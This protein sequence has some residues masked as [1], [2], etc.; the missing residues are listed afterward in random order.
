[1]KYLLDTH[2]L[3]WMSADQSQLSRKIRTIL[4]NEKAEVYLSLAS[5]WE[6]AIKISLGKLEIDLELEEFIQIQVIDNSIRVLPITREHLYT[7]VDL[8]FHHRDPFDRLLICQA[9]A[10]DMAL[11]TADKI[12]KKYNVKSIF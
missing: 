1:M 12:F 6:M 11:L 4:S 5:I 7:Q 3:L 2:I 8:P 10:E 9:I